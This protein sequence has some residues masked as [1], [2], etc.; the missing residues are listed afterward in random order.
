MLSQ[1]LQG[2]YT[3]SPISN[4]TSHPKKNVTS[5]S[6][7][8]SLF[9]FDPTKILES[10]LNP[11]FSL[12]DI[13]WPDAIRDAVAVVE[14]ASKAMF[15]LYCI[16]IAATGLALIGALFGVFT[17]GR[18]SAMVNL[19]LT[20]ASSKIPKSGWFVLTRSSARFYFAWDCFYNCLDCHRQDCERY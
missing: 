9:H 1:I 7:S 3:P 8:T 19:M 16:G 10:E 14:T 20:V 18:L 2:Y 12:D 15:I 17:S 4:E 6:N 13:Q 11:K 5:C